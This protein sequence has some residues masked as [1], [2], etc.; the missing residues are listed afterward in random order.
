[1][2]QGVPD[3][4]KYLYFYKISEFVYAF[5]VDQMFSSVK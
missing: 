2:Q 4:K 3:A 1:M 5:F